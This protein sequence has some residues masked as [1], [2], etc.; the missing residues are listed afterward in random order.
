MCWFDVCCI[1]VLCVCCVL[2]MWCR[3]VA[4]VFVFV[5]CGVFTLALRASM[6]CVRVVAVCAVCVLL[7]CG[8]DGVVIVCV[9]LLLL[10]HYCI[11]VVCWRWCWLWLLRWRVVSLCAGVVLCLVCVCEVWDACVAGAWFVLLVLLGCCCDCG[12]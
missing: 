5:V 1:V 12:V 9:R 2:C 8:G 7:L 4:L 11:V 10:L 3:G 6:L